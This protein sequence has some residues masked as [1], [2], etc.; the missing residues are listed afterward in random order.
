MLLLLVVVTQIL[1]SGRLQKD[2]YVQAQTLW[3]EA[4]AVAIN[5]MPLWLTTTNLALQVSSQ[6]PCRT[7][8][9]GS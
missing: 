3:K 7:R 8:R 6:Q 2:P 1:T 5:V 9:R 4:I